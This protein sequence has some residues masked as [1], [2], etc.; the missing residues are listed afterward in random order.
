MYKNN[1]VRG[2]YLD[3]WH[4]KHQ[5]II[6]L[7]VW[8]IISIGI[9]KCKQIYLPLLWF[10][11]L[12]VCLFVSC[13]DLIM[14]DWKEKKKTYKKSVCTC[15]DLPFWDIVD[16]F[17]SVLFVYINLIQW[18]VVQIIYLCTN[19][20]GKKSFLYIHLSANLNLLAK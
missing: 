14:C 18:F 13:C 11:C 1:K 16:F 12:F 20:A 17:F 15:I 3:L 10:C 19:G 4:V 9:I 6:I 5:A 2:K 7:I 8:F